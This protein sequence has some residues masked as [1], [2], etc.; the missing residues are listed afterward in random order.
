[1]FLCPLEGLLAECSSAVE[2]HYCAQVLQLLTLLSRHM[3]NI[4]DKHVY[5][6][7]DKHVCNILD[8][9]VCNILG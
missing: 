5:N 1:M 4:L 9:H 3:C 8:K 2:G 7:L 6:I